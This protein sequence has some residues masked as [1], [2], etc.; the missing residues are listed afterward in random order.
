MTP[1]E[2]ER[3]AMNGDP[4]PDDLTNPEQ[5][6]FMALRY[7]YRTFRAGYIG[8]EEAGAEKAKIIKSFEMARFYQG[9]YQDT[10]K[11]RNRLARYLAE[12]EKGGCEKCRLALKIFDGRDVAR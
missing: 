11:M 9:I 6:L 3:C 12:I 5:M 7:L 1:K 8:K 4:L 2:I 10:A